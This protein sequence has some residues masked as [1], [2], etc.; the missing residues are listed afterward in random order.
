MLKNYLFLLVIVFF[1]ICFFPTIPPRSFPSGSIITIQEGINLYELGEVL[2]QDSVIRSPFWFRTVS[3]LLGGEHQMKAGQYLMPKPQNVFAIAWR[4]FHGNYDIETVKITIPEGFTVKKISALFDERFT[5][6]DHEDFVSQAPEGYLFP[7]TYFFEVT[8]TASSTIKLLS[9][10]FSRKIAPSLSK[11]ES[12]GRTMDGVITMASILENEA[13][14]KEDREII[15]GILWKRIKL[16]MPLQ[17]DSDPATYKHAGFPPKP[18]SNPG[19]ESIEAAL[20]PVTTPYLYFLTDND[21]MMHY[22]KTFDEHKANKIKYLSNK[23]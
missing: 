1:V 17:V 14:T 5:F 22:A 4:I 2:K 21:G 11:I 23:L 19:L 16:N 7:D 6:F 15:S 10:N 8:A 12:F 9:D 13:R 20:N 3:I 18:I